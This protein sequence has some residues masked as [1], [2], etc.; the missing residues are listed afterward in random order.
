MRFI[1]VFL[2]LILCVLAASN[3]SAQSKK[4][5]TFA[6]YAA[7]KMTGKSAPVDLKSHRQANGYRTRLN[8][9]ASGGVN[10]AGGFII[11]NWGCGTGCGTGA[12]IDAKTGAVYF[13]KELSGYV[14][15][16]GDWTGEKETLEF[17]PNSR[18]LIIRGRPG[19]FDDFEG[20]FYFE[21]TGK[22]FKKIKF[23]E[24]KP[25]DDQ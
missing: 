22:A 4:N 23:V 9:A 24:V 14:A 10:F 15:A 17:K 8:E 6:Q 12:V 3:A 16:W 5:P 13:P 18:L 19:G 1:T 25:K 20:V 7:K 21:W 2:T 11:A